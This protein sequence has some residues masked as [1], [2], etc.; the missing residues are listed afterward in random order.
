MKIYVQILFTSSST[1]WS[2]LHLPS[3]HVLE[4]SRLSK[5]LKSPHRLRYLVGLGL[6]ST[7]S[8]RVI[9]CIHG[10]T[11]HLRSETSVTVSTS[12]TPR[13]GLV[14]FVGH[15]A[16]GGVAVHVNVTVFTRTQ[17]HN[18]F[19]HVWMLGQQSGKRS[20]CLDQLSTTIGVQTNV[21]DDG[22]HWQ[23]V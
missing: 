7:T 16:Q 5:L 12:L 14:L 6:T 19:T 17:S 4:F 10:H 22:A 3:V 21:V 9:K 13:G 18:H 20:G 2:V 11:S 15:N 1:S 23:H 8:M